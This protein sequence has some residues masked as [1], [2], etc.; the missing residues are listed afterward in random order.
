M[1]HDMKNR[2]YEESAS[3]YDEEVRAYGS[4]GHDVI[5]GMSF[6]YVA[7]DE[8]VLDIG[9]GTGLASMHFARAGLQV[10]G[11]D[12]S[13]DMLDLCRSKSFAR[14]LQRCDVTREPIPY[15]DGYFD[16]VVCCGVL[17]FMGDLTSFFSEVTRVMRKGGICAFTIAPQ[18]TTDGFIEEQTAWGVPIYKHA[19]RYIRGLLESKGMEVL[20]EQRLLIKGADKVRYD[21][22]FSVLICRRR[23]D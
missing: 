6:E 18:E 23:Q 4:Y 9:I 17:H 1:D 2:G 22:L 13:Q 14:E 12:T 20:K 7:A 11:L 8:R 10:Y 21:M 15:G 19:P 5:F 16:H 3:R